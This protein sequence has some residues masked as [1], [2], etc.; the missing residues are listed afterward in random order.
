M[1]SPGPLLPH[2]FATPTSGGAA[3]LQQE[4]GLTGARLDAH[5]NNTVL[6]LTTVIN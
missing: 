1:L 5:I 2:G 6:G 4:S 3:L